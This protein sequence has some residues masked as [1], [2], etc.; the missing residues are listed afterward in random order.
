MAEQLVG[1]VDELDVQ[2]CSSFAIDARGTQ[3]TPAPRLCYMLVVT[4]FATR[5][6][7]HEP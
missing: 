1:A 2:K 3:R 4:V 5:K 6:P 7:L